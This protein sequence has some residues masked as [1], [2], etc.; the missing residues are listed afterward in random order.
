[1][2][3]LKSGGSSTDAILKNPSFCILPFI[4]A[5]TLT[6]G[7]MPLCCVADGSSPTNLNQ[8]TVSDYWNSPYAQQARQLM[9]RGLPVSACQRCYEEEKNGYNSHRLVENQAWKKR[10]GEEKLEGIIARAQQGES[11]ELL[12]IDL[13]LGNT[14]NLQCVMCQPR[15]SSKWYAASQK[16]LKELSDL[17]LYAE[18]KHKG[19]IQP[20]KFEWY[21][22]EK[23]WEN[24][25]TVLPG[26]REII[27]GGGEPMLI[28]EHLNFIKHCAESGEAAHIHLRYHTNL[29]IFPEEMVP[30]WEKFQRVEFFASVDG[31]GDIAN[32]VRYPSR[33]E[34]VEKNLEALDRLPSH[35]W[36][37]MLISVHALN[38]HH[39]PNFLFWVK[40]KAFQKQKE[41]PS[42]Q[43]F[44]HPGIVHWP[45]YMSLKVL[46][47]EYKAWV[48][49]R[50]QAAR[51]EFGAE[52]FDKFDGI[53]QYMDSESWAEKTPM[54]RNYISALDRTRGTDFYSL[55]P[56]LSEFLLSE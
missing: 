49:E 2:S 38:V 55:F 37:R 51:A 28:R 29:T 13:R 16:F 5:A 23:F 18:W 47:T 53:L 50:W 8:Q 7:S 15:D 12:S 14:C 48:R 10:L 9:L 45:E 4:H 39:V 27:V 42:I 56:E 24:L 25:K 19:R 22:N 32:Y 41:F 46:P 33:W 6:D 44:V 1:M 43:S 54:L 31:L 11:G 30:Y 34:A 21:R 36:L 3:E 20:E 52:N 26:I 35:I 40:R 17:R